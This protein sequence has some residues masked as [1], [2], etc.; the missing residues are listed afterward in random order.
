MSKAPK[1]GMSDSYVFKVNVILTFDD[2]SLNKKTALTKTGTTTSKM[3]KQNTLKFI[4]Q[5]LS[6][7]I[8]RSLN[9]RLNQFDLEYYICI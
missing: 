5:R 2:F 8:L 9:K 3:I 7:L 1:S 4:G 6:P